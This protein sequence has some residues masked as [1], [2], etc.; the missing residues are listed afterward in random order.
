MRLG[1]YGGSFDPIHYGHLLLAESCREQCDLD[2]IWF[3]P[4]AIPPH[5]L[6]RQL[7]S[8]QHRLE[9]LK[10]A[11]SGNFAFQVDEQEIHRGGV[12]YTVDTLAELRSEDSSRELFFL[13]GA[14]SLADLHTWKDP[15][16]ICE[17][18]IPVVVRRSGAPVPDISVLADLVS[19]ERLEQIRRCQVEMPLIDLR[20]SGIRARLAQG[21]SIRYRTPR[22][23]EEYIK[24]N[25]LYAAGPAG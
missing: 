18:A 6:E 10:L 2:Q 15:R 8:A 19:A 11:T 17:L 21:K 4:A 12:S 3:T 9:M 16:Q 14:D 13:M 7:T 5:K 24:S 22:A 1:I 20:S 25:G 23:V